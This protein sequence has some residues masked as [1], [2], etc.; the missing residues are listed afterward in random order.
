MLIILLLLICMFYF[1][2]IPVEFQFSCN[3]YCLTYQYWNG[4]CPHHSIH[5]EVLH[6]VFRVLYRLSIYGMVER[7]DLRNST[8]LCVCCIFG[9]LQDFTPAN[10]AP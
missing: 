10:Q 5:L 4:S 7:A 8:S 3:R 6:A 9:I 1:Y 2:T